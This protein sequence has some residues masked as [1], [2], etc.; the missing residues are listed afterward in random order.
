[1]KTITKTVYTFDE[2]SDDAKEKARAWY[3][4]GALDYE[5]WDATYEDAKTIGLKLTSFDL[6][7][8]RHAKGALT[9]SAPEVADLILKNHGDTCDTYKLAESFLKERDAIVDGAERDEN[10]EFV[11]VPALE[12]KL[13]DCE[14]EFTRAMVEEYSVTLQK[15]CDWL[16][17]DESVDESILANEYTF[18]VDGKREG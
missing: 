6:D 16:L 9:E 8:N 13:D 7:R 2:L 14:T 10:G 17:S 4:D 11:D 18:T 3:R 15:E 12:E 1:M 5:W